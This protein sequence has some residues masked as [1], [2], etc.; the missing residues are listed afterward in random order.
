VF[1]L[2]DFVETLPGPFE[3]DVKRLASLEIAARG[4]SFSS[5][6]TRAIVVGTVR[7]YRESMRAFAKMPNQAVW[8]GEPHFQYHVSGTLH[9]VMEDGTELDAVA[10]DVTAPAGHDVWVVG[11]RASGWR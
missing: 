1:D 4:L 5:K 2:N 9:L 7:S 3:W 6:E 11:N 8:E 10:G